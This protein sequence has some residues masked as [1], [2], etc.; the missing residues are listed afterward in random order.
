MSEVIVLDTFNKRNIA[1]LVE[2]LMETQV[3]IPIVPGGKILLKPNLSSS[4]HPE[5][6]A[7]THLEILEGVARFLMRKK[8]K[9]TIVESDP[10]NSAFDETANLLQLYTLQEST[11]AK[12]VNLTKRTQRKVLL[13]G[14]HTNLE[15]TI[16]DDV[17]NADAIINL[18]VV[19][20][21]IL[22][23]ASLGIKNLFGL[24]SEK[25]K[26][27]CICISASCLSDS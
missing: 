25:N 18:P 24:I 19:K 20:T 4:N 10:T 1:D 22:T 6:G 17:L 5:T 21:H 11:G 15:V 2:N 16:A 9:V 14:L 3:N 12:I 7:T 13:K 8:Y 27:Q 26:S 23:G